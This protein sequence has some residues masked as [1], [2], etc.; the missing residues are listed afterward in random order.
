MKGQAPGMLPMC[1]ENTP[2]QIE[3]KGGIFLHL[4]NTFPGPAHPWGRDF[5]FRNLLVRF[6]G[7]SLVLIPKHFKTLRPNT[8]TH[9]FGNEAANGV[10]NSNWIKH[11]NNTWGRGAPRGVPEV[12]PDTRGQENPISSSTDESIVI[13][14]PVWSIIPR[15]GH[16]YTRHPKGCFVYTGK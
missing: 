14:L 1:W 5:L 11:S 8:L 4:S 13:I 6:S 3:F 10:F 9:A 12:D 7:L 16:S 2:G 15:D